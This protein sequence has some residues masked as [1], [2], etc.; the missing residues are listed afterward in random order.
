[1]STRRRPIIR[2]QTAPISPRAVELYKAKRRIRCTCGPYPPGRGPHRKQCAG[3]F[4]W[5]ELHSELDEAL[6]PTKPWLWP[7]VPCPTKY[8]DHDGVLRRCPPRDHQVELARRISEAARALRTPQELHGEP[9]HA[10]VAT[11]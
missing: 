3:C 7:Y 9:S 10:A 2:R 6:G 11:D 8:P 1:M 5:W 4:R